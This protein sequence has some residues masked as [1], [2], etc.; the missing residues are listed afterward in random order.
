MKK[1][2]KPWAGGGYL[3]GGGGMGGAS[4]RQHQRNC[5]GAIRD[6]VRI[7]IGHAPFPVSA[8]DKGV[9]VP[10]SRHRHLTSN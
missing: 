3:D 8:V 7:S 4:S 10:Q 2:W 1:Y 5:V 9:L 6:D